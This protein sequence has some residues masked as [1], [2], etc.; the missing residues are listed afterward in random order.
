MEENYD[1]E[2]EDLEI[3]LLLE[4]I[5]L[6]Y[7][8]DFREY[9]RASLR[10]RIRDIVRSE[11]VSTVSR[12]Q[13]RVLHDPAC[14]ER[15]VE[16]LTVNVTSMFRDPTF[17]LALRKRVLPLLKTYPFVRIWHA[18]CST[19]EE[20][21][22]L[23]ILLE[24]EGIYDRCRI[25]A[26]D[27]NEE[28][29]KTAKAGIYPAQDLQ[30]WVGNYL[31]AGGRR[32][33]AEYYTANFGI[34]KFASLLKRNIVFSKHNLVTDR[35][36]NEFHMIF[37]RNVLIYFK[38]SLQN[39]VHSLI[40]ESLAPLGVLALGR[41]ETIHCTVHEADYQELDVNEKLYRRVA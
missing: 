25:Y 1:I 4:G 35:S 19:G 2:I 7:G 31:Q 6:R 14:L 26:T 21:Y 29:L 16:A 15:F 40:Y 3:Q 24:E 13:E 36:F 32:P 34:A 22:S 38:R 28:V 30:G 37:C 17:Y 11:S 10:R 20:V 12:L 27:L 33:F 41:K 18:G 8:Y 39:R 5:Y 23:A 9:A